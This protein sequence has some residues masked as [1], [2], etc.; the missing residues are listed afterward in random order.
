MKKLFY[1][2]FFVFLNPQ[3]YAQNSKSNFI[4]S[5]NLQ[6][7]K[8]TED[9]T[10]C[11]ILNELSKQFSQLG[12]YNQAKEY[13]YKVLEIAEKNNL[14]KR[15]GFA[16]VVIGSSHYFQGD[17]AK[18]IENYTQGL[19]TYEEIED[20]KGV[21]SSLNNI[22]GIYLEQKDYEKALK[23]Y[24]KS[25]EIKK[26]I[27]DKKGIA[28]SYHNIAN[29]YFFKEEYDRALDYNNQSLKIREE[30]GLQQ[31]IA[32]SLN[33]IGSIYSKKGEYNKALTYFNKSLMIDEEAG[34]KQGIASSL[35]YLAEIYFYKKNPSKALYYGT[36]AMKIAQEIGAA[37][38]TRDV[39]K[40]LVE[41]YTKSQQY[42]NAYNMFDLYVNTRDSIL[43]EDNQK[44]IIRQEYKYNY[45]KKAAADSVANAKSNEIK[46]AQIAQQ[47]AELKAKR[48]QQYGLYGG[49]ALVLAF[50]GFMYNRFKVTQNQKAVIEQQKTV[51]EKAHVLLEEKNEE[52]IASIRYAKR[53][54][55]ALLT[56]QKYIERNINRLKN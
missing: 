22:G 46:N 19:K 8:T 36:K 38:E 54:Q 49:F 48:N 44:E 33:N 55:D 34:N 30:L 1:I 5:L 12:N 32:L 56:S 3:A 23:V 41:I 11:D 15:K 24:L 29:I 25:L 53:I 27:N 9:S 50:A 42:K 28:M 26:Q 35:K 37:I 47:K 40:L 18:A 52:I 2:T 6:L 39:A 51:V 4:D 14:K 21:A 43:S 31:G 17:Y 7:N 16:Y 20:K 10:R 13:A 45:E